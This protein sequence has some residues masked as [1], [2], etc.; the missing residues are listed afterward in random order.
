MATNITCFTQAAYW[1]SH[2]AQLTP[3]QRLDAVMELAEWNV[4]SNR[5]LAKITGMDHHKISAF[6]GFHE[7]TTGG[8]F[9]IAALPL[10]VEVMQLKARGELDAGLIRRT[11]EAGVSTNWLARHT[12]YAESS[13]RR[14]RD[15]AVELG[16]GVAA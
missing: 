4:F 3:Q 10:V 5:Q 12:G 7:R 14:W 16:V 6:T 11:L 8:R 13:L 15:K 1:A 9:D 2:R